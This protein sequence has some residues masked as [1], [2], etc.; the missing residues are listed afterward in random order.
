MKEED[1]LTG[2]AF[3]VGIFLLGGWYYQDQFKTLWYWM[4]YGMLSGLQYMPIFGDHYTQMLR[5]YRS[6][7]PTWP[8][9]WQYL[10]IG[11]S[12][13][14]PFMIVVFL[15]LCIR[16]AL[17]SKKVRS[18]QG[19]DEINQAYIDKHYRTLQPSELTRQQWTV[20]HWMHHYGLHKLE[21]GSDEWEERIHKAFQF[22]LGPPSSTKE[23]QELL[24][25]F[26]TAVRKELDESF[27]KDKK[28]VFEVPEVVEIAT[29][30][31]FYLTSAM[32]RILGAARDDYGVVSPYRFRNRL[33]EK[34]E[35]IPIWLS[36]IHISEP[37]RPY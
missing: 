20:R 11:Q 34:S 13:W 2:L 3:A 21:W 36:L 4:D 1:I 37:T 31:H 27:A 29:Q 17:A 33:F 12:V 26:A 23:S 30:S 22:Q 25:E 19:F 9:Y 14:R 32:V 15:P 35:W 16:W 7:D 10:T 28:I 8:S 18:A 5:D 6:I 24:T